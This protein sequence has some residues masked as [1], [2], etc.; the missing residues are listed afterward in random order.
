MT[1]RQ[2][3]LDAASDLVRSRGYA[4]FSYADLSDRVGIRK[5]SIHHHF[6]TKDDLGLAL[7]EQY[8]ELFAGA[9]LEIDGRGASATDRLEAYVGLYRQS[10]QQELGCLCGMMASDIG[11]V[12]PQV[13]AGVRRFMR[14]NRDWLERTIAEGLQ[15]GEIPAGPSPHAMALAL[16]A[17]CQGSLLVA[18]ALG[19]IAVFDQAT[20]S[21]LDTLRKA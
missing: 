2:A 10:L 21:L 12:S 19:D 6:P 20:G 5:A 17:S 13:A 4:G 16:L 7:V 8:C 3:L 14:L 15:R 11:L 1:T 9:L 18:R